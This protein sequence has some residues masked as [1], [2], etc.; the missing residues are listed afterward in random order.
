MAVKEWWR[1]L[2]RAWMLLICTSTVG[3]FTRDQ[4][5]VQRDRGVR[6]AAGVDDDAGHLPGMRLVDEVDQLALAVG[7]AAIRLQA[8]LR[9]GFHAQLFDIG[10]R[11]MAI[12]FR[13]PYPQ[14]VEVRAVEDI[15]RRGRR[16]GPSKFQ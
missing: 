10:E 3:I 12:L 1:K 14:H 6:I 2:S 4:R 15:D 11:R 9:C 8:E 16:L 7:L 5:I 13:L